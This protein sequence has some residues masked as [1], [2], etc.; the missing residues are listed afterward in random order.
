MSVISA[1]QVALSTLLQPVNFLLL[2]LG[3]MFGMLMG[4]LPG[5]GGVV[6]LALLIPLTFGMDPLVAF[7]FLIA[8]QGGQ[9]YGG[10]ITA[11]LI[12]TPGTGVNAATLLDGYPMTQQGRAGEALGASAAASAI[13]ALFGI[14]VLVATIP[15]LVQ[16]LLWFGPPEIFWL[17]IWGLTM[18]AVVVKGSVLSGLI[19]AG[20][21]LLFAMHGQNAITATYRWTFDI[22]MLLD[23][24]KLI[25]PL[26]GLFAVAEMIK[27]VSEGGTIADQQAKVTGGKWKG[28][29][30][31]IKH[32]SIL[33]RSAIIG[34]V[35]GI[36]P[37]VGGTAA[38]YV[39]YFQASQTVEDPES[40]G[41][42]DV[43]GVIA[44]EASNDAKDGGSL[45]PTLGLGIPGSAAMAVLLGAFLLH[46][47]IPGPLLMQNNLEVVAMIIMSLAIANILTSVVGL[48]L[49]EYLALITRIDVRVLAPVVLVLAFFGTFAVDGNIND[50]FITTIFGI[51]GFV[52]IMANISRIPLI[53]GIVLEQIIEKNFFRTIQIANGDLARF[54]AGPVS[55]SLI[56]LIIVSLF[57]PQ[58]RML[59]EKRVDIL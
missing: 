17:G 48:G 10:S 1:V 53:L 33:F 24:F 22:N 47:I 40:F 30:A 58:I 39:A 18:V 15:I 37:G 43:R 20:M 29:K 44:S 36:I 51:L 35:I 28:V 12:N 23:G 42:G 34:T 14:V 5:L 21:G 46:G 55:L 27:L 13:G 52:F 16:V 3:A 59:L 57:L 31:A 2:F 7:M 32:K 25:P 54:F 9:N 38:N 26:I 45:L 11:I 6:A 4:V 56:L 8:V 49:A 41:S 19:S 50:L